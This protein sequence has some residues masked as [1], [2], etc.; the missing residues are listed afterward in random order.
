MSIL[1]ELST[2]LAD[3]V[4]TA[5][6]AVVRVDARRRYG[7]SGLAWRDDG[8]IVTADHVVQRDEGI[9]V[10]L[11]QGESVAARLVGRDSGTDIA[12]LQAEGSLTTTLQPAGDDPRIGNLVLALGPA[13]EDQPMVSFGVISAI[14]SPWRSWRGQ[15]ID[16]IIRSDVTLYPGFSG[17]PLVDAGGQVVG[18]N[19]SALARGLATTLPWRVV[20]GIAG[21]LAERGTVRRGY[22]GVT[23]QPVEI[24]QAMRD[25]TG[26]DQSSGLVVLSVESSSPAESGGLLLGDI[27][28]RL[29][30]RSIAGIEDLQEALGPGSAGAQQPVRV[31]R[32][33]SL[34][35]LSV[36][37][38]ER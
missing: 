27:V 19:T 17:G 11:P 30:E 3:A 23:T 4:Q 28:V 25:A 2:S 16:Q 22:L 21:A 1:T 37:I 24:P 9:V 13:I 15:S 20:E 29:G 35:D 10:R 6:P 26:V 36:T 14:V 7:A 12:L 33:G 32:G 5:A 31:I 34:A 18:M 8:M 38:G